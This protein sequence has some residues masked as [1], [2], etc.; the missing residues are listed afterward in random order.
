MSKTRLA[1]IGAG[2][3]G[4]RHART[5]RALADVELVAVVDSRQPLAERLA[6][7]VGCRASDDPES[8]LDKVD[9]VCVAVPTVSH[10]QV[11]LPFLR[12]GV[13][14][15][16]EKP[17]AFSTDQAL[18]MVR[19][20]ARTKA[21]LQVGHI[22]RFNPAWTALADVA[23]TPNF[24]EAHRYSPF[25]FRSLDVDAVFDLMIHDIDLVLSH[26]Q[27]PVQRINA[28]GTSLLSPT[29][30]AADVWLEFTSGAVAHLSASRAHHESVRQ[31]RLRSADCWIDADLFRRVTTVGRVRRDALCHD[32]ALANL[33]RPA[34]GPDDKAALLGKLFDIRT[35][36]HDAA[37][38]PLALELRDFV[39]CVRG[40]AWPI[41]DGE[42][43]LAAVTLAGRIVAQ[44]AAAQPGR[45]RKSA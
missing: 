2:Y 35:A 15:L 27:A 17:M 43:G 20:A 38:Q 8:V 24:Y 11:A 13:G 4:Q 33:E 30:D 12:R 36:Q 34:I 9:G 3:F 31:V 6:I 26:A 25:P 42:A 29:I 44:L 21:V 1:V 10:C 7:E 40:R 41:V 5:L 18:E 32:P 39:R 16:V 23:I 45:I 28:I 37:A 19:Q 14:V 22:E